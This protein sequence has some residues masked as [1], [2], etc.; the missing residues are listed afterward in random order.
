VRLVR[1]VEARG[2]L[3]TA[4]LVTSSFTAAAVGFL[5]FSTLL[6]SPNA[7]E[8]YSR[9]AAG[10]TVSVFCTCERLRRTRLRAEHRLRRC[11]ELYAPWGAVRC[12]ELMRLMTEHGRLDWSSDMRTEA[13][14]TARLFD[15]GPGHMFGVLV[16][17]D[18]DGR[19]R[20]LRGF[21][22]QHLRLWHVPG[23]VG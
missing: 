6:P 5:T 9:R 23:W 12:R 1:L 19:E 21:S 22:G 7:V 11:W 20:V 14:R 16:C 8:P 3:C 4:G 13:M 15:P 18:A 2:I 17:E 10:R